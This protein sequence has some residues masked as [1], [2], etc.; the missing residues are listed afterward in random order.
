MERSK[1]NGLTWM[2][3]FVY[4]IILVEI[5][6]IKWPMNFLNRIEDT[7]F[8]H[9]YTQYIGLYANYRPLRTIWRLLF[10]DFHFMTALVNIGGNI[11]LFIPLGI[12]LPMYFNAPSK[13]LKT[14]GG[15]FLLSSFF[16]VFQLITICGFFDV[17]DI[18]LNV[19]GGAIG[20]YM[21]RLFMKHSSY[22]QKKQ[23]VMYAPN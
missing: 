10:V 3:F 21:Y 18:L 17:D 5:I 20:F 16:E 13:I 9:R 22:S 4:L 2:L 8:Y 6:L 12:F 19:M 15:C 14:I 23:M 7:L 1:K 11:L